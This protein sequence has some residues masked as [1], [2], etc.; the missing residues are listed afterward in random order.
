MKPVTAVLIAIS[1][2]GMLGIPLGDPKFIMVAIVLEGSFITLA[3][4]SVRRMK[5]A[6]IPNLV[7]ACIVIA[8]N[9]VSP[10]HT[11][12]MRT[13]TPIYNALI[14][15]IGGYI[16]QTLLIITSVL[17]YVSMKRIVKDKIDYID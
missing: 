7:I 9:T 8:G 6:I 13:F 2:V 5:W 4:L 15:L 14:L 1:I 11:E 17:A 10:P 3:I 12:I 16:L